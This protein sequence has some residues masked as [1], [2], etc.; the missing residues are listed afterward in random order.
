MPSLTAP[1]HGYSPRSTLPIPS[2]SAYLLSL[3]LAPA[4]TSRRVAS[5]RSCSLPAPRR[6]PLAIFHPVALFVLSPA[7]R[8]IVSRPPPAPHLSSCLPRWCLAFQEQN[9]FCF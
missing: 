3:R 4:I 6:L 9:V 1:A 5:T 2:G 7:S 8:L